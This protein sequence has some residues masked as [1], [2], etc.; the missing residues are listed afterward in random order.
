MMLKPAPA[1]MARL[2]TI[3][4]STFVGILLMAS[5]QAMGQ[6]TGHPAGGAASPQADDDPDAVAPEATG[7]PSSLTDPNSPH[8]LAEKCRASVNGWVSI[9]NEAQA[10]L[11]ACNLHRFND[12]CL[13]LGLE[14]KKVIA[15]DSP[16]MKIP[17]A[18]EKISKIP[19]LNCNIINVPGSC[20][21]K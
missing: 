1:R 14:R 17:D 16:C 3:S 7:L 11:A 6:P 5:L 10:E 2:L 21:R 12:A 18:R 4:V 8:V 13:R 9:K 15:K 20:A 19:E